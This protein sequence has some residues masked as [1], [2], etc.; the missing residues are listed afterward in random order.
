MGLAP[1]IE[2]APL[3]WIPS[4]EGFQLVRLVLREKLGWWFGA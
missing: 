2:R 3:R 1:R 4:S